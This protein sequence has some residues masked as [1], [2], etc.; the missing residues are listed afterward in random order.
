MLGE[1]DFVAICVPHTG[2]TEHMMDADAFEAMKSSAVLVNI[3]RGK[4]VDLQALTAALEDEKIGG[5][6][7]DVFEQEPLSPDHPLW[8]M[9]NVIITPHLAGM[10]TYLYQ[11]ERRVEVL[12][13][14]VKRFLAGEALMNEVDKV[15]GY[16]VD[17]NE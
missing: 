12:V 3:G 5:A 17:A 1:S 13:E 2:E 15:R 14:N 9:D 4:V 11:E 6:G 8:Q 16:V 10:S 7:L